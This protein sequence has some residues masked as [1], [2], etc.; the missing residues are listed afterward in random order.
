MDGLLKD[1]R[2]RVYNWLR[3][4][5][6]GPDDAAEAGPLND[7]KPL[8]RWQSG[9][10]FPVLADAHG[11][12][13]EVDDAEDAGGEFGP[14]ESGDSAPVG[15][16]ATSQPKRRVVPPSAVGFSFYIEGDA[17][18]LQIIPRAVRYEPGDDSTRAGRA[19]RWQPVALGRDD[20]EARMLAVP[21]VHRREQQRHPVFDERAEIMALWRPVGSGWLVTVSLSNTQQDPGKGDDPR[22]AAARNARGLFQVALACV[23]EAGRVG[24]YPRVDAGLLDDEEREL[25]LQYRF[26]RI[27]AIGHGAAVDWEVANGQVRR[28]RIDF[29]PRL[30]VRQV[31]ADGGP[32]DT[33]V[34][35]I[36][37]LAEI[38]NNPAARFEALGAFADRYG[39][40]IGRQESLV[41]DLA[42]DQQTTA[43][44]IATRMQEALRRIRE[45]VDL[46]RTDPVACRAFAYANRAMAAQMRQAMLIDGNPPRA[47]TW[48]PF[49]LAF[50]LLALPSALEPD[51][52]DRDVVDLIWFPTGGGKTEAYLGLLACVI[53]WRR[54][55]YPTSGGGTAA[56]M[57]YTLRLLTKDQFRR[58]ARLV[59]ALERL[60][61]EV[62][63]LGAEPITL[64]LWVGG[65]SSPNTFGEARQA[66][67]QALS[68]NPD[69]DVPLPGT[70][71]L[72][73]CPWCGERLRLP[74]NVDTGPGHL[75]FRCTAPGCAFGADADTR[76]PCNVVDT[77]LYEQPP[78]LL[79]ATV[80]KFARLAWEERAGVF[81]GGP[82]R[83]PPELII[84]DEL[85]LIASALG[86]IAGLYEAAVETVLTVR[87]VPPKIIASTATIRQ[88]RE[89][90]LRLFGRTP[91]IFPPPGLDADDAYFARTVPIGERPGRLYVGYLAPARDRQHCLAPLAAALLA[92]PELLFEQAPSA[93]R[94]ALQDAW[95]T[96]LIYHGSLRGVGISRNALQDIETLMER[97]LGEHRQR[98]AVEPGE[99]VL[100]PG[101]SERLR[102]RLA[103][104]I[105]QMTSQMSADENASAFARLRLPRDDPNA[106]DL[107]LATNMVSVGLDVARLA[108]MVINGQPLTTAEYIQ[109][110]SRVG[111]GEVPGVVVANYYRDQARSLSHYESFR[112]YHESFY[113]FVE[114]TSV[115]PFT[116]QARQRALH[117]ALVITV[118]HA[119]PELAA[120]ERA[121]GF[122]PDRPEIA[123]LI[124]ELE[125]RCRRADPERGEATAQHLRELVRQWAD[126]STGARTQRQ[127]L[128]YSGRDGDRRDL[129]LLYNYDDK[130]PGL[131][132]T[133][134]SMRNVENTALV[135]IL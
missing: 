96:L 66:I 28:I 116:W 112:A 79:L 86:S 25:E 130:V 113:R 55:R 27:F 74:G 69:A 89:Q 114:P 105:T 77:A 59:C 32:A 90:V 8:N 117:A 22:K 60:R 50:V 3:H 125:R 82:G 98:Q 33:G 103:E 30:E 133:L 34:L 80:D 68:A 118:R 47:P 97:L 75:Y 1:G 95:W 20:A 45:G 91:A 52:P 131:W 53:C 120:N 43:R 37:W 72:E 94:E 41:S 109:A 10:L 24:D 99:G 36:D 129:R 12:D 70:L 110:S 54:L 17:I 119:C 122:D 101:S 100:E 84:Q 67:D 128:V 19:D 123:R 18:R 51:H 57:R 124:Q 44:G 85:H 83:R 88:A 49:Q 13:A 92:G 63:D 14:A 71:V 111:R 61:S 102:P 104:R 78:T 38:E 46:L 62:S 39:N 6:I 73:Q 132:P 5:L 115:T 134:Q 15:A 23:V 121:G 31:S 108:V 2:E 93:D 107:A 16:K 11:L 127:R 76:L 106:L 42:S 135:R 87:G 26:R 7:I 58:A 9:I 48:R 40:W 81:L 35:E 29:L 64:G 56:L 126:Q 21:P 4:C 65:A